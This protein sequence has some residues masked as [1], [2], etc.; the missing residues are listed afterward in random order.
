MSG[1]QIIA[2]VADNG[3]IGNQNELP[4]RQREDLKR[5]KKLTYNHALIM[6]RKTFESIGGPLSN[7]ISIVLSKSEPATQHKNTFWVRDWD[8]ALELAYRLDSS[9]FVIGGEQLYKQALAHASKLYL[10]KVHAS[11]P[12]DARFPLNEDELEVFD[13]VRVE[14]TDRFSADEQ[15]E[16]DWTFETYVRK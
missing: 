10:T 2:A 9:P 5:F 3:V 8:S 14:Q 13:W 7:R 6:G 16:N 4:W 1:L 15:N 12:G 11:P